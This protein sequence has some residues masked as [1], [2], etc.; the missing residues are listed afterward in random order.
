MN[1][2]LIILLAISLAF[3]AVLVVFIRSFRRD[4]KRFRENLDDLNRRGKQRRARFGHGKKTLAE[5]GAEL[6]GLSDRFQTIIADGQAPERPYPQ[7]I[8][9]IAQDIRAP[10]A[11]L[12]GYLEALREKT[13]AGDG[14]GE[15]LEIVYRKARLMH[16]MIEEFFEL[17]A[18]EADTGTPEL[19]PVNLNDAIRETLAALD[20]DFLSAAVEPAIELPEES[21]TALGNPAAIERVL[22]NL[23]FNALRYGG[24]G[25]ITVRLW[26]DGA[27]AHISVTDFGKGISGD[28]LPHVFDRLYTADKARS[29]MERGTGLGLAIAKELAHKQNGD[30][31]VQSKRGIGTVFT[32]TLQTA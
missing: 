23:L 12:N 4:E 22:S 30:I 26:R 2:T 27:A 14:R 20:Q 28:E 9:E 8:A 10:L 25:K 16:R 15:Q 29:A 3:N 21:V 13:P 11:S 7:L 31:A 17:D 6:D 24:G 18:L 1:T 19:K 5:I 32:F